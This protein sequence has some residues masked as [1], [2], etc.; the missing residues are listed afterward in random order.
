MEV[1]LNG[2]GWGERASPRSF[3]ENILTPH[4]TKVKGTFCRL[5]PCL[6]N[7]WAWPFLPRREAQPR[8][9]VARVVD[10]RHQSKRK[11]VTLLLGVGTPLHL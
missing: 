8:L 7:R 3:P 6:Q 2:K 9:R 1:E 5:D 4:K 11:V 10:L